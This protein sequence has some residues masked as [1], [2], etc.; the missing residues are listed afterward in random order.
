[1]HCPPT[2]RLPRLRFVAACFL[3]LAAAFVP[4]LLTAQTAPATAPAATGPAAT[5]RADRRGFGANGRAPVSAAP[6]IIKPASGLPSLYVV[7]D[8]T[9]AKNNGNTIEGWGVPFLTYFDLTKVNVVNAA[10]GGRSTRTF[11]NEGHLEELIARLKQGDTVLIQW[12]H[13]DS[14]DLDGPTGRGSLHGLGDETIEVTRNGHAEI[15]HTFGWYM[16]YEIA[17]I[18]A[19]GAIPVVLTLTIRDR[20]NADGTIERDPLPNINLDNLNRFHEPPIYSVWSAQVAKQVFAP[21]LDVHNMIA[22]HDEKVGKD[23]V[24]TYYNSPRDP[25]H[26]NPNGA[27]VDAEITLACLKTLQGE[28]VNE[29]L[30]DKG[31][32]VAP[33]D[34]KYVFRNVLPGTDPSPDSRLQLQPFTYHG[35]LNIEEDDPHAPRTGKVVPRARRRFHSHL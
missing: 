16:R 11:M 15:L 35:S 26:R 3:G 2:S 13:N 29:M 25:T 4:N 28:A 21:L 14:Y 10:L 9:A 6:T 27:A 7:G 18:R 23:V 30:N 32:A 34:P 1:M 33:A 24:S 8:S 22:D 5:T 12:G 17:R 19:A 20:W 31:K